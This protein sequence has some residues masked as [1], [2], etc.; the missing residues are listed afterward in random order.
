M[1]RKFSFESFAFYKICE[2]NKSS[3][4]FPKTN[5]NRFFTAWNDLLIYVFSTITTKYK[6]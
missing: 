4:I 5:K 6:F 3:I 1:T 2:Y